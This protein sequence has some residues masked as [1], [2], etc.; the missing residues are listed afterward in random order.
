MAVLDE[1]SRADELDCE[2]DPD[3]LQRMLIRELVLHERVAVDERHR[4]GHGNLR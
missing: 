4:A 3:R 2:L 1:S